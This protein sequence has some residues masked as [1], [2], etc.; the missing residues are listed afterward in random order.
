MNAQVD[1][2]GPELSVA[3]L[4]RELPRDWLIAHTDDRAC[5]TLR[6][7]QSDPEAL[8]LELCARLAHAREHAPGV[9]L[10]LSLP[11]DLSSGSFGLTLGPD[12]Q[13]ALAST[14]ARIELS[15]LSR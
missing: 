6:D 2:A 4:L 7:D 1:I 5:A 10:G 13:R 12:A 3:R 15:N 14:F 11:V 8:L 9:T